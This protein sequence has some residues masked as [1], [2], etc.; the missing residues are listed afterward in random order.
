MRALFFGYQSTAITVNSLITYLSELI[1]ILFHRLAPASDKSIWAKSRDAAA[2]LGQKGLNFQK[3]SNVHEIDCKG[4][5]LAPR[6]Y[7]ITKNMMLY[8]MKRLGSGRPLG[9]GLRAKTA[10]FSFN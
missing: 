10:L 6:K 4:A 8:S 3:G 2:K 9:K 7:D 5:G 1:L